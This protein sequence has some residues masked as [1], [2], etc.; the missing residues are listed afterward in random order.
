[1][2]IAGVIIQYC[3]HASTTHFTIYIL[4]QDGHIAPICP[5]VPDGAEIS[6][7]TMKYLWESLSSVKQNDTKAR[8]MLDDE[9]ENDKFA[10][11]WL[12]ESW[13]DQNGNGESFIYIEN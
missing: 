2:E 8:R 13:V 9:I 11:L 1:M 3:V 6:G 12:K 10:E 7:E 4:F 5:V